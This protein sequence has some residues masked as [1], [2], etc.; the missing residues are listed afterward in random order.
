MLRVLILVFSFFITTSNLYAHHSFSAFDVETKI[1]RT[2]VITCYDFI[3]PHILMAIEVTLDDGSKEIW[4]IE[5]LVP[6]GWNSLGLDRDFVK[7]GDTATIVGFPSRDGSTE[8]MLSAI[9]TDEGELVAR[10]VIRQ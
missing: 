9:R 5:S 10:D 3:Q 2:G 6:R 4:Q 7:L 8:M 1:A